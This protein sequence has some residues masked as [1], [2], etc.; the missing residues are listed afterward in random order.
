MDTL[1]ENE[2]RVTV[3]YPD[4]SKMVFITHKIT[5]DITVDLLKFYQKM[6]NKWF[7]E[8]AKK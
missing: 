4:E 5:G 7:A 1:K 8:D 6:S 2:I 3:E